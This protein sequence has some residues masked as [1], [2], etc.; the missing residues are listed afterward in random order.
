MKRN[1]IWILSAISLL[2]V[3]GATL[4]C[5]SLKIGGVTSP[6]STNS[7]QGKDAVAIGPNEQSEEEDPA[8]PQPS[9]RYANDEIRRKERGAIE[10]M[11]VAQEKLVADKK[12]EISSLVRKRGIVFSTE[13]NKLPKPMILSHETGMIL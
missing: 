12:K 9:R 11:I 1:S 3:V 6:I 5:Q 4:Y 7:S 2:I 13:D 8:A 10:R